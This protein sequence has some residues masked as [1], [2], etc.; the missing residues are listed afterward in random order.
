[1][2]WQIKLN[3]TK[4]MTNLDKKFQPMEEKNILLYLTRLKLAKILLIH[5]LEIKTVFFNEKKNYCKNFR[6]S[7]K[8]II[9]L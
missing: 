8:S 5:V 4:K 1:M 9:Y 3:F 7:W 6:R 2:I